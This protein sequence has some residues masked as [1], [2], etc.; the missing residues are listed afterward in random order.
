MGTRLRSVVA[1]RPKVLATVHGRPYLSYLLDRLASAGTNEVVLLTGYGAEQVRAALGDGY[2][3]MRLIHWPETRPLGTGGALRNG[4]P[5]FSS[6]A[7]L[8]QNGDS[9][10]DVDLA[11]FLKF[12]RLNKASLSMVL[13]KTADPSR[14]GRVEVD[15]DDLVVRFEE[16]TRDRAGWVNAGIYLIARR[17]IE[18][19]PAGEA[20]SLERDL[21]PRWLREG[22]KV[23]GYRHV[24]RFLDIGTPESY[25]AAEEY[26]PL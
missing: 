20:L 22:Q 7:V 9:W 23:F 12:Q 19:I 14:F 4:L 2:A 18:Q 25:R 21:I 26:V 16:K 3:G 15:N 10:C 11:D 5:T 8:L 6:A 17:L 1:D 13:V 24:G